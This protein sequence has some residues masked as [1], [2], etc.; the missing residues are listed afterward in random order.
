[1]ADFDY[2]T[3]G[4]TS[5]YIAAQQAAAQEAAANRTSL[6]Q[7]DFLKLLTTQLGNQDPSSPV[8]N[9]QMVTTMSQLS[10]VNNLDQITTGMDSVVS[11]INSSSALT[12]SSLV[13]RSVLVDSSKAFFDGENPLSA[14]IDA[15]N[16]TSG[17]TINVFD[18]NGSVVDS[19]TAAGGSGDMDF[20]WDGIQDAEGN[21]HPAGMYTIVATGTQNGEVVN[22]PVSTYATVGS[23]TLGANT[24]QTSLNL[25]GYGDVK[26][27]D[28]QEIAM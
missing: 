8:D 18:S 28:V 9:N 19:Y 24:S 13:G 12:A 10:I 6:S 17:I 1:M 7:E 26:L 14:K 27:S 20:G 4:K 22:L 15:G 21:R 11:S 5:S 25:I 2:S 23:V 16:G 3:I